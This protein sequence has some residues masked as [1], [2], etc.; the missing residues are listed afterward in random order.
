[1][2]PLTVALLQLAPPG[3]AWEANL[4]LGEAACRR[5]RAMGADIA[6]FPE[7]WSNGYACTVPDG[8]QGDLYRHPSRWDGST[9]PP[10]PAPEAVWQGRAVDRESPFVGHFR[11][12]AAE[13][14]MAIA[15]TYLERWDGPPRNSVSLIDR[16]GRIAL[17]QAKVHTCA[18]GLPEAL[19]TPGESFTACALDTAIGEV[20]VGAMIC[21]D[22][23]FPESARALMLAG[24]ELVLVPNACDM[25]INRLTQLRARAYENMTAVAMTNYAGPGFGHS[26][27]FDGIA[28]ADG[29]SRDMLVVEAGEPAGV[30]PAVFDLDALRDYRRRE[31]WGNAF[32]RPAAYRP[33]TE[34]AV[35]DPF[36]R[37][38]PAG[39]PPR[40][41]P[42]P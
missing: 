31:T 29:R 1:M 24:A 8:L 13:L 39:H 12:L 34:E 42:A 6:L 26:I 37:V 18:F 33:L 30:Y 41:R 36:L 2:R 7:M 19:L 28:F 20:T 27:A 16:R 40:P 14:D 32:R 25:E 5:A 38:D 10:V 4:V 11:A 35:R 15:L 3:S 9:L 23:E 21:Y 17:H 22:R